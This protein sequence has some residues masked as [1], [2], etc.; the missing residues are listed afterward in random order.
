MISFSSIDPQI[1]RHVQAYRD[2][3]DT[4]NPQ[5]ISKFISS[6]Q[7][8]NP[9][10]KGESSLNYTTTRLPPEID[11]FEKIIL[12]P[13]LKDFANLTQVF[14]QNRRRLMWQNPDTKTLYV[15]LNSESDIDDFI[16]TLLSFIIENPNLPASYDPVITLLPVS[17]EI[18]QR[19]ASLWLQQILSTLTYYDLANTP[20]YF[21]SSNSHSLVNLI[22][23]YINSHHSLILDYIAHQHPQIYEQW[24]KSEATHEANQY[25]DFLYHLAPKFFH[26]NPAYYAEKNNYEKDLGIITVKSTTSFPTDVQIIPVKCIANS[27]YLDAN[28]K[29]SDPNKLINSSALILNIQYPLGIA[30]RYLL[31]EILSYFSNLKSVHI[32]GKAAIL[33][34]SVGDIQIPE[35]VL[36]E[37]TNN[38]IKLDNI[39]NHQFNYQSKISKILKNQKAACVYGTM[40]ENQSQ[41]ESYQKTGFNIIEMESSNY[42][43]AILEKYILHGGT[44][45]SSGYY[46][47]EKLP[48]DLGIINY[49]S[50]NPLTQNLSHETLDF[51][52][53]ETAYLSTLASLQRIIDL[54]SNS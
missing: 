14:S 48:I 20:V 43:V 16:N 37:I 15:I 38:I 53:I 39:F 42:L 35:V 41:V 40:L 30:A 13:H 25:N 6:Y 22:G 8:L 47:I 36:D 18:F 52:G 23:G 7:Q 27:K 26:D 29:V 10:I 24:Y 44:L 17:P 9:L 21:V 31:T 32:I 12:T 45:G 1:S 28:L 5:R 19:Q 49:A 54:E 46:N 34:G 50:D 3:L 4:G 51:A 11:T 33:N 2:S